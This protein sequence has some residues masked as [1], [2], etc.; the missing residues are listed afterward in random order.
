MI[1]EGDIMKLTNCANCGEVFAKN[2]IDICP[3]CYRKEEEAFQKVYDF[4]RRQKN[5]SASLHEIAETTEVEEE[6]IV[7]FLKQNR[8]R[9]SDFPQLQYP[10]ES[11]GE[12]ISEHRYCNACYKEFQSEWGTAKKQVEQSTDDKAEESVYYFIDPKRN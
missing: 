4:L 1:D 10:C 3:K 5:R 9:A 2:I 6:L 7:K 8:L 12:L 11:C